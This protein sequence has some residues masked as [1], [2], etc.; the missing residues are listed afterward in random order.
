MKAAILNW[1]RWRD[2]F[3]ILA[4][5]FMLLCLTLVLA[6]LSMFPVFIDIPYH[7]A[8]TRGFREAGGVVTWDFWDAAPAGRPHIY[9]PLLHVGMS[10]FE[11]AG[12]SA[13]TTA[14]LVCVLMFPL[15][16]LSMWWAMR[17][18]FGPRAAFCSLILAAV[19]YTFFYQAGI[20]IAASL[21]LVLTPLV[22]LTLEEGRKV[23]SA[24][25]LAMCLYSHLVL[26][27]LAALALFIYMLHRREYW[28]RIT[29]VLV[30]A[31]LFYLPWGVVV[32]SN[33]GSFNISEPGMG[34][35]FT[36]HLLLWGLAAAGVVA[37]YLRRRQHYLLP[38]YL[39]SMVPIAFFYSHRFWDGHVFLPLAMLGGVAFD[40]LHGFLRARLSRSAHA[41][42]SAGAL[43]GAIMAVA[44]AVVFFVDPAVASS[45]GA[46]APGVRPGDMAYAGMAPM[47]GAGGNLEGYG[48]P[49]VPAPGPYA[50]G[51]RPG[52]PPPPGVTG[53]YP[54]SPQEGAASLQQRRIMRLRDLAGGS[55]TLKLQSTTFLVLSGLEEARGALLRG[56]AETFGE[57]N[58][59][60][61][62]AIF[63]NSDPGD[64]VFVTE[65]RLGD[66]IYAMTGRYVTQGMFHEV[67]P[68]Y[69]A[70][71]R[72]DA[73]LA[74]VN[75]AVPVAS[76]YG[77]GD[78]G[79]L[80][81]RNGWHEVERVGRYVLLA[82]DGEQ[83]GGVTAASAAL[84][85]WAAYALVL[86][87]VAAIIIDLFVVRDRHKGPGPFRHAPASL[88]DG[89]GGVE[90]DS[91]LAVV[92]ARDEE[93]SVGD[94]VREIRSTCPGLDIL[95]V[96]DGSR[97]RT[98]ERAQAEGAMVLRLEKNIGVG[99]AERRGL[100]FALEH[101]YS[102]VVRLD[103]DGQ[104]PARHIE[105][106]MAPLLRGEADA[107]VGSRF[108]S[109]GGSG[110]GISTPRRLGITYL[111][112][113]LRRRT[114]RSFTDPTSG[115]RAYARKAMRFIVSSPPRRYP[116]A[117]SL[118]AMCA[119]GLE[120]R[121]VAVTM[122]ERKAG[123]SS[124]GALRGARI[125]AAATLDAMR[126]PPTEKPRPRGEPGI[127]PH[128]V[129]ETADLRS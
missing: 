31:Y 17:K 57:E 111:G 92:P 25:L 15:V 82:R 66:L 109:E 83:S 41:G 91:A 73:S 67:Q 78:A 125:L 32:V 72:E 11:D 123:K 121:E 22:F 39:F 97:D 84:P 27:H 116:E 55:T 62:G 89:G 61:M 107:V 102:I 106:L 43:A 75:A 37:C 50:P 93:E 112:A 103:G 68:I 1:W 119:N 4:V 129:S 46:K 40:R 128:A 54:A 81:S 20:T 86:A 74:V 47:P 23:A 108:L 69:K 87:A 104:H 65:G 7:M 19:P 44:V 127:R 49:G 120:V 64:A 95:V 110:Y 118:L 60:L 48:V 10:M 122:R 88:P 59:R 38:A 79:A 52:S 101:G 14:T 51:N 114:G 24:L 26:G 85:L 42:V 100:E 28:K 77:T 16:L 96:D 56:N 124:I 13:E 126:L 90:V 35:G 115:F 3:D 99:E 21:V 98:G 70:D 71:P 76:P 113:L 53:R 36:L 29:G 63:E 34:N 5:L 8:V 45:G 6:N 18:L 12:L 80:A 94:V 105:E 9:P 30:A 2:V 117:G 33:L 58:L